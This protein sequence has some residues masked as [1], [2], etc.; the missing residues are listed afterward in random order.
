MFA[1]E[2][3]TVVALPK[4]MRDAF[5]MSATTY[6]DGGT[7]KSSVEIAVPAGVLIF[8]CPEPVLLGTGAVTVVVVEPVGI[9]KVL[10]NRV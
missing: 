4:L 8:K 2:T 3:V 5:A 1:V 7:M 10:L 9:V 6:G